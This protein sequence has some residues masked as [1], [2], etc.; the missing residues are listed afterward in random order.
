MTNLRQ[1]AREVQRNFS[2]Y[3]SALREIIRSV[4]A[5]SPVLFGL[6]ASVMSPRLFWQP[7]SRDCLEELLPLYLDDEI[8]QFLHVHS[9]K[10]YQ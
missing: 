4:L 3:F 9:V 7:L 8:E 2:K 10:L 6:A 5:S 1:E